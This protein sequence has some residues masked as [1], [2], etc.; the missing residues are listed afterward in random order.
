MSPAGWLCGDRC[1]TWRE[2]DTRADTAPLSCR[3]QARMAL[4]LGPVPEERGAQGSRPSALCACLGWAVAGGQRINGPLFR[5]VQLPARLAQQPLCLPGS[6]R[7]INTLSPA[8]ITPLSAPNQANTSGEFK[9]LTSQK[10]LCNNRL[11][12]WR[13]NSIHSGW[14][15]GEVGLGKS[16]GAGG[17]Q[18]MPP[19][20][21]RVPQPGP[22]G[23][24]QATSPGR[25]RG[26]RPGWSSPRPLRS[27]FRISSREWSG[28]CR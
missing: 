19:A 4:A 8:L 5:P 9:P 27:G 7:P 24:R 16:R 10:F 13:F 1:W 2:E 15:S 18:G 23:T 20:W 22:S 12:F 28:P 6:Q 14:P 17:C 26:T 25:L 11:S 21:G 3:F